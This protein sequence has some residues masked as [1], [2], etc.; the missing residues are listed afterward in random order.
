[1]K[2]IFLDID[3]VV[4]TLQISSQPFNTR[5]GKIKRA[6]GFYYN[7][8]TPRDKQVSNIQ[9]IE[10]LNKLC[11][12]TQAS[13]VIS[14]TWRLAKGDYERTCEA[15]Y[16]SGLRPEIRI[17]GC[18]PR[19]YA[20]WDIPRGVE[21]QDFLTGHPDITQY[22][23]LDDDADMGDLVDHLVQTNT[24]IGFTYPDYIKA[25]DILSK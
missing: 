2:V 14:S 13:I 25:L 7:I 23:I 20:G 15:L 9:A 19:I 5:S 11:I 21:I 17:I 12:E 6:G 16:N 18:T 10:W 4:N 22:V 24:Y 3:G 1:M 8:C